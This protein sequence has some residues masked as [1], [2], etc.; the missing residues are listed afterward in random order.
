MPSA[1]IGSSGFVGSSLLSQTSFDELYRSTNIEEIQGKSF[2]LLVCAGAPAAKWK[3]NADPEDD[4]ENLRRLMRCLGTVTAQTTVLISTID[5]YPEPFNVFEETSIETSQLHSYGLHRYHLEQFYVQRFP[6]AIVIRLPGLFG[7]G[8]RK[9]FLFDLLRNPGA[10]HL[11][12]RN[13][14]FQFYDISLLW[15]DIQRVLC[16][17]IPIINFGTPPVPAC[18]LAREC[19]GVEFDNVT[20]HGPVRYDMRTRNARVFGAT[21]DYICTLEAELA[22]IRQFVKAETENA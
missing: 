17:K 13:S 11:T 14:I 21:G 19:F 1:L 3:A 20:P 18:E 22:G 5:V 10:L 7:R 2:E 6:R 8:L 9:N 12:H 16:R 15:Q 4:I